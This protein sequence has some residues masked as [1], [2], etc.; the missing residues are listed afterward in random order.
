MMEKESEGIEQ[1]F[2]YEKTC[3]FPSVEKMG[4]SFC[5]VVISEFNRAGIKLPFGK[6]FFRSVD[7]RVR[8][9]ACSIVTFIMFLSDAAHA[10]HHGFLPDGK[11]GM[12]LF[13][14]DLGYKEM[15]DTLAEVIENFDHE[16]YKPCVERSK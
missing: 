10:D 8:G 15:I 3:R 9:D 4:E 6:I 13:T 11:K 12:I 2:I 16:T 1:K 7:G 14:E 5:I